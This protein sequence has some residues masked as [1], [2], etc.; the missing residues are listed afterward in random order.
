MNIEHGGN[1]LMFDAHIITHTCEHKLL[2]NHS[3][4]NMWCFI[5]FEQT[6]LLFHTTGLDKIAI[7]R[8][9]PI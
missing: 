5:T 4:F 3:L 1:A 2:K 7:I 9:I 8:K 6:D